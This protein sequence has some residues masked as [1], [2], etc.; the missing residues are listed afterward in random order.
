M[1][2]HVPFLSP[3]NKQPVNRVS[4]R[5][6]HVGMAASNEGISEV[7]MSGR[8]QFASSGVDG[9]RWKNLLGVDALSSKD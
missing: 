8:A 4:D 7:V 3:Q 2:Y 6:K 5:V 1:K 9:V